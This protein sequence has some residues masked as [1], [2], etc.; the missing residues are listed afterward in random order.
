MSK[1]ANTPI[2]LR[3][4]KPQHDFYKMLENQAETTL[5]GMSAL[6]NWFS[7]GSSERCQEIRDLE[8]EADKQKHELEQKLVDSFVTP[9]DREDIY[10]LSAKLDQILTGAKRTV[11]EVE[12]LKLNDCE[13]HMVE[14]ASIL[15]EGTTC[16]AQSFRCLRKE[17]AEA[18]KQA[19]LA[20]KTSTHL[21]KKYKTAIE[22][23]FQDQDV[24]T[25]IKRGEIYRCMLDTAEKI[26]VIGEKLHFITLKIG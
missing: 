21:A 10:D 22:E 25:I 13:S 3:F 12:A 7:A 2:W 15:E 8:H 14:M 18:S 16:I 11:R 5:Q 23:L 4:F 19:S 9:F 24:T 17:G 20:R 6:K 1:A 26:D